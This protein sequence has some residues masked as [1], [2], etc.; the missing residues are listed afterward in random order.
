V[1]DTMFQNQPPDWGED[2]AKHPFSWHHLDNV[3]FAKDVHIQFTVQMLCLCDMV[4]CISLFPDTHN[5]CIE[6]HTWETIS[7]LRFSKA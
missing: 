6:L 5:P 7:D 4:D 2:V 1:S 3:M